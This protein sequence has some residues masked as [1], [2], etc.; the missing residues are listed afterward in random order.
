MNDEQ[1][2]KAEGPYTDDP[3]IDQE[4]FEPPPLPQRKLDVPPSGASHLTGL[5]QVL[6]PL[7]FMIVVFLCVKALAPHVHPMVK[8][9]LGVLL[10]AAV[11]VFL[12][13]PFSNPNKGRSSKDSKGS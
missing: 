6:I 2:P 11:S 8:M 13:V 10:L 12:M 4:T 9:I 1:P 5:L 3:G 7:L